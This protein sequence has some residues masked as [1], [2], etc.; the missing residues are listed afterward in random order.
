MAFLLKMIGKHTHY[1]ETISF[2]GKK[3]SNKLLNITDVFL[4]PH[5]LVNLKFDNLFHNHHCKNNDKNNRTEY[6][7][8]TLLLNFYYLILLDQKLQSIQKQNHSHS[9][10]LSYLAISFLTTPDDL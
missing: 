6:T 4:L 10:P 8:R 1:L 2:V 7:S 5:R 9:F 3:L